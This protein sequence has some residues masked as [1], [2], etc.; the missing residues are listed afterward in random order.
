VR[1]LGAKCGLS[2]LAVSCRRVSQDRYIKLP[3]ERLERGLDLVKARGVIEPEQTVYL[4]AVPAK[5]TGKFCSRD[6]LLSHHDVEL[7]LEGDHRRQWLEGLHDDQHQSPRA[8]C[9]R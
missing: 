1:D 9:S 6:A 2:A 3:V 8:Y 5:A 4:L 7:Q